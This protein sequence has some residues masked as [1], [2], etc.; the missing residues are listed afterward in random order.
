W[1]GHY[2]YSNPGMEG[3]RFEAHFTEAGGRLEGTIQDECVLGEALIFGSLS[4]PAITF[5]KI[6][7]DNR[8]APIH[9]SGTVSDDCKSMRGSWN[10]QGFEGSSGMRG[11]SSAH[12]L[13]GAEN[14]AQDVDTGVK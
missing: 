9:Y 8:Y 14:K 13:D 10:I 7:R 12:R 4:H 6:Y 11:T 3:S 1:M 5:T 2:A